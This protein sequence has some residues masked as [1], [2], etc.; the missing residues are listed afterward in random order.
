MAPPPAGG[1]RGPDGR[2]VSFAADRLY[3]DKDATRRA[4]GA[5][6]DVVEPPATT[7]HPLI[8]L[9]HVE[10]GGASIVPDA[11]DATAELARI[12]SVYGHSCMVPTLADGLVARQQILDRIAGR[13][14]LAVVLVTGPAG[15]GK[16]T[17]AVQAAVADGRPVAWV[18]VDEHSAT[19]LSLL[20]SIA[21]AVHA[22]QPLPLAVVDV[23]LGGEQTWYTSAV[24][25][26]HRRASRS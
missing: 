26:A 8:R 3:R 19:P 7:T 5:S 22:L 14:D 16:T 4:C 18:T 1:R 17:L 20:R 6:T 11:A 25:V 9:G 2:C 21:V 12:L 10:A 15:F 23:L 24:A 13:R